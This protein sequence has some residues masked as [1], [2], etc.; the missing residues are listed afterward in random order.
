MDIKETLLNIVQ[1]DN[2]RYSSIGVEKLITVM[3][4]DYA[5]KQN[6]EVIVERN[7]GLCDMIFPDGIDDI[8]GKVAVE[9]KMSRHKQLFLKVI[10]DIIGRF[11]MN[12]GDVNT[13]LLIVV[14]EIDGVFNIVLFKKSNVE[15]YAVSFPKKRRG[16]ITGNG[17][18][19]AVNGGS[20]NDILR[21]VGLRKIEIIAVS[22]ILISSFKSHGSCPPAVAGAEVNGQVGVGAVGVFCDFRNDLRSVAACSGDPVGVELDSKVILN[23]GNSAVQLGVNDVSVVLVEPFLIV[24]LTYEN[25]HFAIKLKGGWHFYLNFIAGGFLGGRRCSAGCS[26]GRRLRSRILRR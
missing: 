26:L 22:H 7:F 10:Y 23:S 9:I 12:N 19:L 14:N 8:S 17:V 3:L 11:T 6:K 24:K 15:E 25:R 16:N 18:D 20:V 2:I 1:S 13:L 5:Q 4:Q 21:P